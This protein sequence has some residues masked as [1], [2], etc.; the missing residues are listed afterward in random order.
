MPALRVLIADDHPVVR[1]GLRAMLAS[2]G[3]AEVVGEAATGEQAV[4]ETALNH[5]DV[6]VMDLAMPGLNGIEATRQIARANPQVGVLVLTMHDDDD[7]VF[8][9]MRAGA[10]GYVLKGASQEELV[11]AIQAV[12][13]GEAIFGPSVATRVLGYFTGRKPALAQPFPE[14]TAREREVLELI[15][16]GLNNAAIAQRLQLAPKTVRNLASSVFAK[17]QVDDRA[18]AMRRALDEGLGQ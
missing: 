3:T 4:R 16:K 11:Q 7:S 17:L 8:A 2:T 12:A 14:L 13:R 18:Q 9:A 1:D 5:P 6:V 10:R 15:A